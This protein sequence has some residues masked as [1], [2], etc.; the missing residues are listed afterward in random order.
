M[1]N[2]IF[3]NLYN[4]AHQSALL[5]GLYIFC[6][7]YLPYLVI[8]LAGIFLLFHHEVIT[9][10]NPFKAFALKWKEIVLVFF[11]GISA[12]VIANIL[13]IIIQAPRPYLVLENVVPLL[14]KTD[15]SFPSGHATF[16]MAL[17]MALYFSHKKVGYLFGLVAFLIGLTRII[18]GVHFPIDILGGFI[19]GIL[20]A[21]LI[22]FISQT[23]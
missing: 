6:A 21:I 8:I 17:A 23:K 1:N 16:Y 3:L 13:K 7:K 22:K 5:D 18:I 14:Q 2:L 9:S 12:W 4:L 19:L 20:V 10:K 11:S 15:F